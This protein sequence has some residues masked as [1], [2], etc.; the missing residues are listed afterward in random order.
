MIGQ[1]SLE[2]LTDKTDC[3][4]LLLKALHL[5]AFNTLSDTIQTMSPPQHVQLTW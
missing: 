5:N 1:T 3:P 4:S 2:I